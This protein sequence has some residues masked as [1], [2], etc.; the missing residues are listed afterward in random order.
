MVALSQVT[1]ANA[2]TADVK[3]L[4]SLRLQSSQDPK[5]AIKESAK[6]FETLFMRQL[7]KSMRDA[8]MK[9]G[10]MDS[11]Q[12][13]ISNDLLDDQLSSKLAGMPGGLSKLIAKQLSKQI[14]DQ[15][16]NGSARTSQAAP[17]RLSTMARFSGVTPI[18]TDNVAPTKNQTSFVQ[19]H[20]DAAN[21]AQ[22]QSGIPA[23]FILAQAGHESG[24]GKHEIRKADGSTSF[25]LF[26]IKAGSSWTGKVAEV[27]TTEYVDGQAVSTKA[28]F[29]AYD[30]YAAAFKDYASM[31]GS[32]PR[33]AAVAQSGGSVQGFAQGLQKAGYAT[34]PMY[35]A[36]LTRAINA[37]L[38]AQRVQA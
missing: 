11:S 9:S 8:T 1:N 21:A 30:S 18:P 22:A 4:G 17:A 29:R 27:A 16:A 34:D 24:W 36:K 5:A 35:A 2:L 33:Y 10:L 12:S 37:T 31:I 7:V 6:Q 25:N 20:T 19:Q 38:R 32:N 3:A 23:S 15:P 28:R 14:G 26:G 13:E